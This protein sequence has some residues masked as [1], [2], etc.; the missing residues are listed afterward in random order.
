MVRSDNK[1]FSS[2]KLSYSNKGT[3]HFN[4]KP[5]E[6]QDASIFLGSGAVYFCIHFKDPALSDDFSANVTDALELSCQYDQ[7]KEEKNWQ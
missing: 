1:V 5:R 6:D 4:K 3:W 7:Q 2:E